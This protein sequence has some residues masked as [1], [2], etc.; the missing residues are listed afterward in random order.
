MTDLF[1]HSMQRKKLVDTFLS[2]GFALHIQNQVD[3]K[4]DNGGTSLP[5][6]L[7]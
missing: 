6:N 1:S 7:P 2:E 4:V 5:A 3:S